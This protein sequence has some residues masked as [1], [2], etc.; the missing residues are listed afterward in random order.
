VQIGERLPNC[1]MKASEM[2]VCRPVPQRNDEVLTRARRSWPSLYRILHTV[3]V[4]QT[5]IVWYRPDDDFLFLGGCPDLVVPDFH[6]RP[7]RLSARPSSVSFE[8]T[9]SC[10]PTHS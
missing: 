4:R 10:R 3:S 1:W 8:A 6:P 9:G 2:G 7:R 5:L